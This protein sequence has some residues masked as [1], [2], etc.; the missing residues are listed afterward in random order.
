MNCNIFLARSAGLESAQL[1]SI[2][3]DIEC[4]TDAANRPPGKASVSGDFPGAFTGQTV[5]FQRSFDL[6]LQLFINLFAR[7]Q[8]G[9]FLGVAE[10]AQL[11]LG[12]AALAKID[13]RSDHRRRYR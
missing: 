10:E 1:A 13:G 5:V 8:S 2:N 4:F 7:L 12:N 3:A 6:G 11:A 9:W